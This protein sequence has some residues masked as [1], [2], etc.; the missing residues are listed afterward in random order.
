MIYGVVN[1]FME[2]TV[3]LGLLASDNQVKM[4]EAVVDTGF[5]GFLTLP[6]DVVRSLNLEWSGSAEAILADGKSQRFETY[7]ATVLWDGQEVEVE[8]DAADVKPLVGMNLIQGFLL[9]IHAVESGKVQL[10]PMT[11]P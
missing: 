11:L 4:I 1:E 2:A 10:T 9:Q 8:I 3:E 6:T 5:S 7:L